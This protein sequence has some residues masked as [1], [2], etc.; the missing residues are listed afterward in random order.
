MGKNYYPNYRWAKCV[1]FFVFFLKTPNKDLFTSLELGSRFFV[2]TGRLTSLA[3]V[4]QK[5]DPFY[6][7]PLHSQ[8]YSFHCFCHKFRYN[9]ATF[10]YFISLGLEGFTVATGRGCKTVEIKT[11]EN[12]LWGPLWNVLGH[13][14]TLLSLMPKVWWTSWNMRIRGLKGT[15]SVTT[16][17]YNWLGGWFSCSSYVWDFQ[18]H[19]FHT[20]TSFSWD[21][22]GLHNLPKC[23]CIWCYQ[24]FWVIGLISFGSGILLVL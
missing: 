5:S 20:D 14:Y 10:S 1:G 6:I 4:S 3:P 24:V 7:L 18:L 8:K 12:F 21:V 15:K 11:T 16:A 22:F 23:L 19:L 2:K 17:L 9:T 13:I